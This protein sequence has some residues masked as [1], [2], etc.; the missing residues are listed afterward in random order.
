MFNKKLSLKL[1]TITLLILAAVDLVRGFLHTFNIWYA[2]E[3]IAKMTQT[4]DTLHLMNIFGVSNFLTAFIF[5]IVALKAK[6]ITPYVL[7][8]IPISYGLGMLSS[9]ITGV[10]AMQNSEWNGQYMM[11]IYLGA[12]VLISLNY[13]ISA[14]REKKLKATTNNV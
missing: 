1:T 9:N 2:S 5:I 14:F 10:A 8:A 12:T 13:F 6:E 4:A 7:S 11:Y 3:N